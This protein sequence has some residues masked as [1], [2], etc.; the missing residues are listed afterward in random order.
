MGLLRE[1]ACV[2]SE[3]SVVTNCMQHNPSWEANS[4]SANQEITRSLWNPKVHYRIHNCPL[5]V[6]ILSQI[7][8]VHAL[9]PPITFLED[10]F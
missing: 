3:M 4:S 8:P 7:D 5:P 1:G 2:F 6:P 9:S 10:P